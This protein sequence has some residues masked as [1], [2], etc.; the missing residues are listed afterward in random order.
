LLRVTWNVLLT[1]ATV[2]EARMKKLSGPTPT[3]DSL[4]ED[5]KFSTILAS[6]AVGAKLAAKLALV[7][8]R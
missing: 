1:A 3:M 7:S 4:L 2:P 5:R 8:Q 6:A